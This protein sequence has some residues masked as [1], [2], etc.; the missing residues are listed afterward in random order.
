MGRKKYEKTHNKLHE[1]HTSAD[2]LQFDREIQKQQMIATG[3][4]GESEVNT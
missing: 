4:V 3:V 1:T 2:P